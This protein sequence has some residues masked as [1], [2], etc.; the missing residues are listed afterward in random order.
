MLAI[1]LDNEFDT[2]ISELFGQAPYF[3][4]LNLSDGE[5]SVVKNEVMGEGPKSAAFLRS[6]GVNSAVYYHMGEGVYNSFVKNSMDVYTTEHT[7]LSLNEIH[8]K[9]VKKQ[10]HKVDSSNYKEKLDPGNGG[11][12]SCGCENG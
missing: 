2:N 12:C 8:E 5:L 10:L 9:Y 6:Y 7:K 11:S 3:G 4:L 1:P